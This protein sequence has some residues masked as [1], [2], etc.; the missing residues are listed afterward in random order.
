MNLIIPNTRLPANPYNAELASFCF[1]QLAIKKCYG[2]A[3]VNVYSAMFIFY[4]MC[5]VAV[6][7]FSIEE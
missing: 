3:K 5:F 6:N 4:N 7:T 1:A 2:A